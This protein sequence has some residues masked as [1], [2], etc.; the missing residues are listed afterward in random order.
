MKN[1]SLLLPYS[2]F[3]KQTTGSNNKKSLF[4]FNFFRISIHIL[5]CVKSFLFNV[6]KQVSL[7]L[8]SDKPTFVY[9][10]GKMGCFAIDIAY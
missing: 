4:S 7:C 5:Q 6:V 2:C 8:F 1:L 9:F 10:F 3:Q